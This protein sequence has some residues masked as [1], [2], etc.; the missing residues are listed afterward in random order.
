[1]K[2]LVCGCRNYTDEDAA[3]HKDHSKVI[4][5]VVPN[6]RA[7]TL[8]P[9][10][11]GHVEAGS[12]VFTDALRSYNGLD[13]QYVHEVIDHAVSY[14]EGRIHTNG[15][16]NFWALFKRC[17]KGTHVSVEPFHLQPYL[18]SEM[19]RFNNREMDDGERFVSGAPG[20]VG[21]RLTYKVL[22]GTSEGLTTGANG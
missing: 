21:K 3:F 2:L 18:D 20:M 16:E 7:K 10:I 8:L 4:A 9:I 6:T 12:A 13:S 1:M 15:M 14:V 17:I 22:I 5:K 11:R 19:F